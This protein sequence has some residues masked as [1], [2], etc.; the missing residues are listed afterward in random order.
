M[1]QENI[2]AKFFLALRLQGAIDQSDAYYIDPKSL[3]YLIGA[4]YVKLYDSTTLR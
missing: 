2:K 4:I 3:L 1:Q